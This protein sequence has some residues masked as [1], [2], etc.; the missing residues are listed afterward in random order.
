MVRASLWGL[1]F[2]WPNSFRCPASISSSSEPPP[3]ASAAASV[4]MAF[5]S[6]SVPPQ[7]FSVQLFPAPPPNV[8]TLPHARV[9]SGKDSDQSG[10]SL[11]ARH[12][13]RGRSMW[14]GPASGSPDPSASGVPMGLLHGPR[15]RQP[16]LFTAVAWAGPGTDVSSST[17]VTHTARSDLCTF[18]G[19]WRL[20]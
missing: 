12:I 18:G 16:D 8:I 11:H 2:P 7:G 20:V 13:P 17:H 9:S 19:G 14:A 4:F 15:G 5:V 10:V 6:C 1:A 3:G